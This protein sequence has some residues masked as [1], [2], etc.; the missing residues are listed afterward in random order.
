MKVRLLFF[1]SRPEIYILQYFM[2]AYNWVDDGDDDD[3]S[4]SMDNFKNLSK[5]QLEDQLSCFPQ[6]RS[7]KREEALSSIVKTLNIKPDHEFMDE[8]SITL[9]YQCFKVMKKGSAKELRL[10]TEAIGL[11]AMVIRCPDKARE[12]YRDSVPALSKLLKTKSN[13]SKALLHS[14]A[15]AAFFTADIYTDETEQ[16]MLLIWNFI[17]PDCSMD[18][19]RHPPAILAAAISAWCFL[20]STLDGWRL[21]YKYWQGAISYFSD[22]IAN[23]DEKVRKAASVALALIF[24]TNTLE[25]FTTHESVTSEK[26]EEKN[27]IIDKLGSQSNDIS[28][29]LNYF[30]EGNCPDIY[31][32]IGEYEVTLS[33]WSQ[34]IQLNFLEQF[35]GKDGFINHMMENENFHELFELL[36]KERPPPANM[37]FISEREE[38]TVEF[39]LPRIL[40]AKPHTSS[41]QLKLETK[42]TKSPNSLMSKTRTKFL[43]KQR[44]ISQQEK[45]ISC[46][47]VDD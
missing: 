8:N 27:K 31:V 41:S 40:R 34:I 9:L 1:Q 33:T 24:E 3:D 35:L 46:L 15:M 26:Q 39:Y 38:V 36:P 4:G 42:M 14:L 25:K 43:N 37:P 22:L 16:A 2:C 5:L 17:N 44:A 21:S 20:L 23:K 28:N 12:V 47:A 32:E 18:S 11:I 13:D 29:V 7:P 45:A 6:K 10:A 19:S 30:K